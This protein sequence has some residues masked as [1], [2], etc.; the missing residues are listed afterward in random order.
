MQDYASLKQNGD[1]ILNLTALEV[2]SKY[3]KDSWEKMQSDELSKNS[4]GIAR[5]NLIYTQLPINE[6]EIAWPAFPRL[7]H[8]EIEF[9]V[10]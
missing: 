4:A 10:R 9:P 7:R 5:S 6:G 1:L 3:M 8:K 2:A